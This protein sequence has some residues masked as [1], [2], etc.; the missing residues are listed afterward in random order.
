MKK[1][2]Y[3]LACILFLLIPHHAFG[4]EPDET[5]LKT[6]GELTVPVVLLSLQE[7]ETNLGLTEAIVRREV[8]LRLLRHGIIPA[9]R[10]AAHALGWYLG[11]DILVAGS[12][13]H[14]K[15][16]FHRRVTYDVGDRTYGK[17]GI[18]WQS[19]YTGVHEGD[20]EIIIDSLLDCVD[21]FS[22]E[23]LE[24]NNE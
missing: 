3:I 6:G 13:Y 5:G 19:W 12:A 14:V 2:V 16:G 11:I 1:A 21:D 24:Y 22:N 15:V 7:A 8:E 20:S 10:D 4:V 23:F 17:E 9:D 18:T